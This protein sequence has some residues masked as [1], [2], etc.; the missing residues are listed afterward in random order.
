[1]RKLGLRTIILLLYVV[2]TISGL[3]LLNNFFQRQQRLIEEDMA[4]L[5][6]VEGIHSMHLANSADSLRAGHILDT[7]SQTRSAMKLN[8]KKTQFYSALFLFGI[9]IA[10]TLIFIILLSLIVRPMRV[11][12]MATDRI[13]SGDFSVQIPE[14]GIH[15][16]KL[17]KMSFNV[18]SRELAS[19]QQKLLIAEKEMI[20]KDLSRILAH[21]IKNPLTPI[22]LAI[23][24]LEERYLDD[25]QKALKILPESISVITQ[26]I[27]NLRL[28]AQQFSGYAKITAAEKE[29]FDPALMITDICQSYTA[30][31]DIRMA[32]ATDLLISFDK[33]HFYQVVTNILQN[34]LDASPAGGSIHISLTHE[35][36]YLRFSIRDEGEGIA[37]EDLPYVFE[38]YFTRKTKGTGLGLALVKK[39]CDINGAVPSVRSKAGNGTEFI[40]LIEEIKT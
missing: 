5:A 6:V 7:Y 34:A 33:T 3:I 10:S 31:Y 26:E 40:L 29:S 32:L 28:L 35:G 39:L 22:Q 13:R 30:D 11:L 27:D 16:I 25:P 21:E 18:M 4:N 37:A 14:T 20:W 12:K 9:I 38:P 19:I 8:I 23:Q 17:L 24:R 15:D 36:D 1:M 2:L